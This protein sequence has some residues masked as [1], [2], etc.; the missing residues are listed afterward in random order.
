MRSR[1]VTNVP[2]RS[3]DLVMMRQSG[4]QRRC[5][6]QRAYRNWDFPKGQSIHWEGA[7]LQVRSGAMAK[8]ASLVA[9]A[10]IGAFGRLCRVRAPLT[11]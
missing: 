4:G 5:F 10:V 7:V 9:S 6:T 3:A 2:R 8:A 11:S 1:T